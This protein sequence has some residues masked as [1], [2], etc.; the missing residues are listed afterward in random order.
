VALCNED[1]TFKQ[2][3][4]FLKQVLGKGS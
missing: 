3:V 1:P 4:D 2:E